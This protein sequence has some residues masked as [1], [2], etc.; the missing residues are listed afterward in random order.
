MAPLLHPS[1]P[2]VSGRESK[3]IPIQELHNGGPQPSLK[4]SHSASTGQVED[5]DT[6]GE[7]DVDDC[8]DGKFEMLE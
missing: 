7:I 4:P 5:M 3:I 8:D 1:D 2:H 6:D